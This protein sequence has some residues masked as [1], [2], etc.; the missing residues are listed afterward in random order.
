MQYLAPK[1][2]GKATGRILSLSHA[3]EVGSPAKP[4][5]TAAHIQLEH[6]EVG[7]SAN[8]N[9]MTKTVNKILMPNPKYGFD[10]SH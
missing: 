6:V 1:T 4:T 7:E 9:D 10:S 2:L 5:T 8:D 3:S